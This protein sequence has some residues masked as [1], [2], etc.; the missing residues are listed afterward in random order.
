[1]LCLASI[2]VSQRFFKVK[3]EIKFDPSEGL[4]LY[5]NGQS[6]HIYFDYH[7]RVSALRKANK[8]FDTDLQQ[9]ASLYPN[10]KKGA[11]LW[12]Y[13]SEFLRSENVTDV[14]KL[15]YLLELVKCLKKS[16]ETVQLCYSIPKDALVELTELGFRLVK[17]TSYYKSIVREWVKVG[18]HASKSVLKNL[19]SFVASINSSHNGNLLDVNQSPRNNRLDSLEN[20]EFYQPYKVFSGQ[21]HTIEGFEEKDVV[22]FRNENNFWDGLMLFFKALQLTFFVEQQQSRL[23]KVYRNYLRKRDC[24]RLWSLLL[25]ERGAHKYFS[26]NSIQNLVHVSTLTKSEYRILLA[27]AKEFNSKIILVS[28][29]TLKSLSSSERLIEADIKGYSKTVLP[30]HIIVRDQFSK[31]VFKGLPFYERIKLGGRFQQKSIKTKIETEFLT[32]KVVYIVLTNIK[33]CSDYLLKEVSRIDFKSLGIKKVVFRCHPAEKYSNVEVQ[34]YFSGY[35]II[36][37]TGE[38]MDTCPYKKILMISGPTTGALE[39]IREGVSLFWLPYIWKDGI[40]FDDIMR[41]IGYLAN[42]IDDL[43]HIIFENPINGIGSKINTFNQ[44]LSADRL[45]SQ[46]INSVI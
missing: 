2:T 12:C 29:R 28:S 4:N 7:T 27:K 11:F 17:T 21:E 3:L 18:Y 39:L 10:D 38:S 32:E 19:S 42:D 1:M 25:Y 9:A 37:H 24:F 36:N 30:D 5:V 40:L 22:I 46:Q 31:D 8:R 23:A 26:K 44:F 15:Y 20:Y 14:I 6:E 34:E 35:D 33:S 45:I 13:T 16:V 43:R 41:S